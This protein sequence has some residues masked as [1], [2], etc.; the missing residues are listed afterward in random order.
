MTGRCPQPGG[1]AN[2]ERQKMTFINH[3]T[4]ICYCELALFV[5]HKDMRLLFFNTERQMI[6]QYCFNV[7]RRAECAFDGKMP[8]IKQP[9]TRLADRI[10]I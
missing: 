5:P 8:H 6:F 7:S 9:A 10:V 4:F 3:E 1:I 2:V